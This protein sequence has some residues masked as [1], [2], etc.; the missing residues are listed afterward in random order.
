MAGHLIVRAQ[1]KVRFM[2]NRPKGIATFFW[3]CL[4]LVLLGLADLLQSNQSVLI[5]GKPVGGLILKF[6]EILAV[7][8]FVIV[9]MGLFQL[10]RWAYLAFMWMN[11]AGLV[12]VVGNI[13]LVSDVALAE[14]GITE[15]KM[16]YGWSAFH[17]LILVFLSI[18]MFAYRGYFDSSSNPPLEPTASSGGA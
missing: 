2:R 8:S 18:W 14:V 5:L 3:L 1:V 17:V 13:F 10:R 9:L 7:A 4:I 15:A 11:A 16:F 6:Y 12:M